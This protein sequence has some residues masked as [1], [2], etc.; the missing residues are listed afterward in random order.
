MK[1]SCFLI[2]FNLLILLHLYIWYWV[3]SIRHIHFKIKCYLLLFIHLKR[4]NKMSNNLFSETWFRLIKTINNFIVWMPPNTMRWVD[5]LELITLRLYLQDDAKRGGRTLLAI[6]II[7]IYEKS[8]PSWAIISKYFALI[9][10]Y[11]LA[12]H[13]DC[14]HLS[15]AIDAISKKK[16]GEFCTFFVKVESE[17]ETFLTRLQSSLDKNIHRSC[18]LRTKYFIIINDYSQTN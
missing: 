16:I 3:R 18:M 11:G 6:N 2:L 1:V 9:M 8:L 5:V 12:I 14:K 15:V 17:I 7:W 13:H 4:D 10:K